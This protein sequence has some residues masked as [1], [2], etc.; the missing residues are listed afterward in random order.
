MLQ[1]IERHGAHSSD[2]CC[3][4]WVVIKMLVQ[5][6]L[7]EIERH[8]AHSSDYCCHHR[9]WD[10]ST[11]WVPSVRGAAGRNCPPLW[12]QKQVSRD[13]AHRCEVCTSLIIGKQKLPTTSRANPGKHRRC[14]QKR[15]LYGSDSGKVIAFCYRPD[16]GQQRWCTHKQCLYK[17]DHRQRDCILFHIR[18]YAARAWYSQGDL[19]TVSHQMLRSMQ[20]GIQ[21]GWQHHMIY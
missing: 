9:S 6:L 18:C 14:T 20:T 5:C 17:P 3:T 16:T 15:G 11:F 10:G 8:G 19:R 7:Q 2:Y 1:E 12:G 13:G 4:R 21:S